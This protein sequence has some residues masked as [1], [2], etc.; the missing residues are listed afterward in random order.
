MAQYTYVILLSCSDSI[1]FKFASIVH[2][3]FLLE[4]KHISK[5]SSPFFVLLQNMKSCGEPKTSATTNMA[6]SKIFAKTQAMEKPPYG[7]LRVLTAPPT[8]VQDIVTRSASAVSTEKSQQL[9][10]GDKCSP[11]IKL[12]SPQDNFMNSS[13][14]VKRLHMKSNSSLLRHGNRDHSIT[15]FAVI[16]DENISALQQVCIECVIHK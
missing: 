9:D 3:G 13:T 1:K 15:Q 12:N 11:S 8:S 5:N 6:T 7:R 14:M 2:T 10:S 16:D 4:Y